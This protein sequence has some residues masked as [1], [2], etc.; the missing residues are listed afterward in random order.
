MRDRAVSFA[1]TGDP[2]AQRPEPCF[3]PIGPEMAFVMPQTHLPLSRVLNGRL[4]W[5]VGDQRDEARDKI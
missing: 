4:F 5:V 1:E 2:R 3:K